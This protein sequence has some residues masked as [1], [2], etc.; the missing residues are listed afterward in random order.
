MGSPLYHGD[1]PQ[2]MREKVDNKSAEHG[3]PSRLP[4]FDAYWINRIKGA[5]MKHFEQLHSII[6]FYRITG[7]FGFESL[8]H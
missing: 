8:F 5:N 2:I 4:T 7:L 3:V 6:T 1:Y